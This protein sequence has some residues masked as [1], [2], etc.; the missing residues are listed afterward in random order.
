MTVL[1][2]GTFYGCDKIREVRSYIE[3]PFNVVDYDDNNGGRCFPEVVTQEA[4]LFVPQGTIERYRN[5][6]G[7][8]DFV[9][10]SEASET[11]IDEMSVHNEAP[12]IYYNLNGQRLYGKPTKAIYIQ[13]GKKMIAK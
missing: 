4:A 11:A 3:E 13:N 2:G 1:A 6:Q 12:A 5:K 7:W 8:R 10:I 9:T